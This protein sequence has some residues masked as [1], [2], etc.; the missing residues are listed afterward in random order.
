M[1]FICRIAQ[2]ILKEARVMWLIASKLLEG[3][4]E[5]TV[6][7]NSA[8]IYFDFNPPVLTNTT[9]NIMLSTFDYDEDGFE[10]FVD[11]D[12]NNP[13]INPDA[14]EIPNNGIDEDCDGEDLIVGIDDLVKARIQIFPNPTTGMVS[15]HL[16]QNLTN[17]D[18]EIKDY[19]GKSILKQQ[20]ENETDINLNNF[21]S[22]IYFL[23]IQSEESS[24][25]GKTGEVLDLI[26]KNIRS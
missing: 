17:A 6:I 13:D 7:N 10:L 22:G 14:E 16:P 25:D 8:G 24:L 19:S 4:P 20:L 23:L 2:V 5:E 11:C 9:E 21:S 26:T 18:L 12:D 3:I 1:I 15:I